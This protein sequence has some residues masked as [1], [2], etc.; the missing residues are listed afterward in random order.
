M[1]PETVFRKV[2]MTQSL[3]N[4]YP[5]R[6]AVLNLGCKVNRYETDAVAQQFVEAGYVLVDFREPAEVYVLNTCAVTGEAARKSGQMLRRARKQAPDAVIVVMGCHIQL[7]GEWAAADIAVGNQG[8]S[9]V[10]A[11]VEHF[12]H[13]WSLKGF[14][15]EDRPEPMDLTREM[16]LSERPDFE[17]FGAVSQQ[18]ETRAYLKI[19]DGCNNFCSYC[20]I[21]YARGRVRSRAEDSI[22]EEARQLVERGFQEIVLTGIH[23]CSYGKERGEPSTAL[24]TLCLKLA[25]LPGL[26]RIRLGSLEPLSVTPEFVE[27]AARN[28][29]LCPHFHL[30]L[31]SGSEA[32]L[33][34]MRRRYTPE[35]YRR[36]VESLRA[37]YGERLGLTTDVIVGFPGETEADFEESLAFC[38]EMGFTRMHL[39]PYSPREGTAAL[40]LP[41][42]V[43]RFVANQRVSRLA[44]VAERLQQA[45]FERRVG[46]VDTVLLEQTDA[47]GCFTGYTPNYDPVVLQQPEVALEAGQLLPVQFVGIRQGRLVAMPVSGQAAV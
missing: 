25:E 23:V 8:K 40:H 31:Q 7:G 6:L 13:V 15:L 20:A 22:L 14:R 11:A 1:S 27:Q 21:P 35:Q 4:A 16:P 18:S 33:Q 36:V 43:P 41:N 19:Q 9:G 47:Q 45:H 12:R 46:Q 24:T 10:F 29:K 2:S 38:E 39:F 17:D 26:A 44:E 34:R 3:M 5:P 42:P 30:S 37:A 32:T 28:P